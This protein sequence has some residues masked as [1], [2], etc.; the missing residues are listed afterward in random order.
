MC[1]SHYSLQ[2]PYAMKWMPD[3]KVS[4]LFVKGNK[5]PG[6]CRPLGRDPRWEARTNA[7]KTKPLRWFQFQVCGW[8]L[9]RIIERQMRAEEKTGAQNAFRVGMLYLTGFYNKRSALK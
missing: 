8:S 7:G 3:E 6:T 9:E 1:P 4:A 2:V 5:L